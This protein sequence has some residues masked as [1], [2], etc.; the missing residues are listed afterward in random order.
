MSQVAAPPTTRLYEG[1]FLLN[2]GT[3][4]SDYAGCVDHLKEVLAR[5][6]AEIVAM[7]KWDE[8]RLAYEIQGQRRGTFILVHFNARSSQIANIERDVNLSEIILRAMILKGEHIGD[9]ELEVIKKDGGLHLETILRSE[10]SE[11]EGE[12]DSAGE[13]PVAAAVAEAQPSADEAEAAPE[14][15]EEETKTEE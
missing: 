3:V 8:R 15:S 10:P 14:S 1:L 5:A 4:A 11:S 9:V 12:G 6:E 7:Q 13:A 2:Q